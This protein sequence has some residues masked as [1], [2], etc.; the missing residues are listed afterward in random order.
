MRLD[1]IPRPLDVVRAARAVDQ[2]ERRP[3]RV[4]AA[5]DEAVARAAQDRLH[6][7]AVGFDARRPRIVEASAV[8][9]APEVR[10]ELEVGAAPFLPHRA[11]HVLEVLL[12]LGMRAVERVPGAAPPAAEGDLVRAQRLAVGVLDE[13][14]GMLL[15]DVRS[16]LG[17]ERRDPD[18]RLESALA[19]LLRARPARCRRTPRRSRASRPSPA[20]SRRRSARTSGRGCFVA[21]KSR[22]SSTCCAVTLRPEAI[23]RA[24]AGRRRGELQRWVVHRQA[25]ADQFQA[26]RRTTVACTLRVPTIRQDRAS[27]PRYQRRSPGARRRGSGTGR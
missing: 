7:A 3:D 13:P 1:A 25:F 11:E 10:V 20:D 16:F 21:M 9:R 22:L 19:D 23:P 26:P 15:E 6:P 17:D 4:I 27:V 5:E 2:P 12:H 8:H 18:R 14:V 24:P